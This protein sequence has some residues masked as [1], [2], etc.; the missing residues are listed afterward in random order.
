MFKWQCTKRPWIIS[1]GLIEANP[2][3]GIYNNGFAMSLC[4]SLPRIFINRLRC[5]G[6]C[7]GIEGAKP[8][9]NTALGL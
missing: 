1:N 8:Q 9:R 5:C 2:K 6:F 3:E 4:V 7:W